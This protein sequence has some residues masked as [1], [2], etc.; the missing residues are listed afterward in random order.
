MREIMCAQANTIQNEATVS[1]R[2]IKPKSKG[3]NKESSLPKVY[4][5]EISV[6]TE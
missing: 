5:F 4:Q 6:A 2:Q 3:I 1:F